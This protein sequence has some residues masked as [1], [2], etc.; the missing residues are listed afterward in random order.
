MMLFPHSKRSYSSTIWVRLV[1]CYIYLS[2]IARGKET[3]NSNFDQ[4][5]FSPKPLTNNMSW[6]KYL[7]CSCRI[8]RHCPFL[9]FWTRWSIQMFVAGC[10]TGNLM[11]RVLNRDHAVIMRYCKAMKVCIQ[12]NGD[13]FLPTE[14]YGSNCSVSAAAGISIRV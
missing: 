8:I 5:S 11:A 7:L 1:E 9:L 6:R 14:K 4:K 2:C 3:T 10:L 13:A 12:S